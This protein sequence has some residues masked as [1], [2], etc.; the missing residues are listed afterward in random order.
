[1]TL[2]LKFNGHNQTV[3]KNSL[4]L[5]GFIVRAIK[6]NSIS[7]HLYST[8]VSVSVDEL[9]SSAKISTMRSTI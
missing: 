1:M 3:C 4:F 2:S 6:L 9:S 7:I 5:I 8:V